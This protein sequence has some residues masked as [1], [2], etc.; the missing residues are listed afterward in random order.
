MA[1]NRAKAKPPGPGFPELPRGSMSR[2]ALLEACG[3]TAPALFH[4]RKKSTC[5]IDDAAF[6][7]PRLRG[8]GRPAVCFR[9][10]EAAPF[11]A[12]MQAKGR[13]KRWPGRQK[14]PGEG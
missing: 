14:D 4:H 12:F 10:S 9:E 1:A 5:G 6:Y 8:G 11:I 7:L 13:Y 3:I 2:E